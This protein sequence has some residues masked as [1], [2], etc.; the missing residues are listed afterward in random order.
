MGVV[1]VYKIDENLGASRRSK[2][3]NESSLAPVES[4]LS[5][6]RHTL[7]EVLSNRWS[8]HFSTAGRSV[9]TSYGVH[10][11]GRPK[12][13]RR[14]SRQEAHRS[15]SSKKRIL[16]WLVRRCPSF[17]TYLPAV[18]TVPPWTTSASGT[19]EADACR[20]TF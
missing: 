15:S 11:T 10:Q 6:R 4:S 8:L 18:S 3:H 19:I 20:R 1:L 14:T 12:H 9:S 5:T 13:D 2:R 16:A 7:Q 17:S